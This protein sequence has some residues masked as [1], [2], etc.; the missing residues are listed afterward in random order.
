MINKTIVVLDDEA[1]IL[2]MIAVNLKK[3][4]FEPVCFEFV[5]EFWT[6]LSKN[7]PALIILDLMLNNADGF[8]VCKLIRSK[9]EYAHI[10]IIMLTARTEVTD[11]IVGLEIGADDYVTK[12]FSPRELLA[13]I[14]VILRRTESSAKSNDLISFDNIFEMNLN[15]YEVKVKGKKVDL[16]TTEFKIL[17]LLSEKPG[18]V[19]SRDQLLDYLW[20][21]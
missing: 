13:R 14:K 17:R 18:W 6:Y 5:D 11:K 2:E 20:G 9:E 7:I 12:P 10:P 3:S 4:G 16:T 19:Y 21:N 15:K 8:E 1:D